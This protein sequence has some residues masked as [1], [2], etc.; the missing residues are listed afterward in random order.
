MEKWPLSE[1]M[2][3]QLD[4]ATSNILVICKKHK[5]DFQSRLNL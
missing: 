5:S 1:K 3:M 4:Q 2:T